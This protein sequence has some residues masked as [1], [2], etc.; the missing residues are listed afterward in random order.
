VLSINPSRREKNTQPIIEKPFA[1][2]EAAKPLL[3]T[4][5]PLPSSAEGLP[6]EAEHSPDGGSMFVGFGSQNKFCSFPYYPNW[7]MWV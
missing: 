5:L 6:L 3:E 1:P 4:E 2:L 7:N